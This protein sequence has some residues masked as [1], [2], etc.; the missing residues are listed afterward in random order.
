VANQTLVVFLVFVTG[1]AV[2]LTGYVSHSA[3]RRKITYDRAFMLVAR[4]S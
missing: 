1:W 2:A 3:K 4:V